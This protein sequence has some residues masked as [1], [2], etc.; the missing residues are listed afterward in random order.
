LEETCGLLRGYRA[1]PRPTPAR[2]FAR[3]ALAEARRRDAHEGA[4]ERGLL[5]RIR[6]ILFHPALAAAAAAAV[7]IGVLIHSAALQDYEQRTRTGARRESAESPSASE[8]ELSAA[9]AR[10]DGP[11]MPLDKADEQRKDTGELAAKTQASSP[12]TGAK[13]LSEN[14]KAELAEKPTAAPLSSTEKEEAAGLA[15]GGEKR[16]RRLENRAKTAEPAPPQRTP[17]EAPVEPGQDEEARLA[18]AVP[19][20]EPKGEEAGAEVPDE[21]EEAFARQALGLLADAKDDLRPEQEEGG[22]PSAEAEREDAEDAPRVAMGPERTMPEEG[23]DQAQGDLTPDSTEDAQKGRTRAAPPPTDPA[24]ELEADETT[25]RETTPSAEADPAPSPAKTTQSGDGQR[26][27][28]Q[29]KRISQRIQGASTANQ[30]GADLIEEVRE[31]AGFDRFGTDGGAAPGET[32]PGRK[33]E[34]MQFAAEPATGTEEGLGDGAIGGASTAWNTRSTGEETNQPRQA[35]SRSPV[36]EEEDRQTAREYGRRQDEAARPAEGP[37]G[38]DLAEKQVREPQAQ[39][40]AAD[41]MDAASRDQGRAEARQISHGG[42]GGPRVD[43]LRARID[44]VGSDGDRS[45]APHEPIRVQYKVRNDGEEARVL[46]AVGFWPN[47][48]IELVDADG[49]PVARTA[50]GK[51]VRE[52][53]NPGGERGPEQAVELAPGGADAG[54][55]VFDLREFFV[56]EE[57]GAYR[58]RYLLHEAAPGGWQGQLWSNTLAFR[59]APPQAR[60]QRRRPAAEASEEAEAAPAASDIEP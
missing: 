9:S 11:L 2:S 8:E 5:P 44:F 35:L 57:P 4:Q 30:V 38:T 46:W 39:P 18:E 49:A 12:P 26:K 33:R 41:I 32:G 58:V 51:R 28:A 43:G 52:A 14:R 54:Y 37:P 36:P 29:E 19:A 40:P 59:V 24:E 45:F 42:R 47:H 31:V 7:V 22:E 10:S 16:K 17:A 1:R 27:E 6:S 55:P 25:G 20:S 50:A 21:V 56:L 53:F 15:D 48:R 60:V 13:P 3:Q 34:E 23:F